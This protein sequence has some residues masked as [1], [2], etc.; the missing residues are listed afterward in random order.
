MTIYKNKRDARVYENYKVD[1]TYN[2]NV[3]DNRETI[4]RRSN[5]IKKSVMFYVGKINN[6]TN[7]LYK[8]I[9]KRVQ[10]KKETWQYFL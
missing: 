1:E 8:T 6:G 3:K 7:I 4:T 9:N 5:C 2:E 10:R